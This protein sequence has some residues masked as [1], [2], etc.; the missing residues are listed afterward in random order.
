MV[1]Q[2]TSHVVFFFFLSFFPFL[3]FVYSYI[4][5]NRIISSLTK[6]CYIT[7]CRAAVLLPPQGRS[8][9][10]DQS[11]INNLLILCY[12]M[13]FFDMD[14]QSP[15]H[16][17][18]CKHVDDTLSQPF[19]AVQLTGSFPLRLC[20]FRRIDRRMIENGYPGDVRI[21]LQ[22]FLLPSLTR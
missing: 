9:S 20:Q 8:W 18:T 11:N 13:K 12:D 21:P 17:A 3:A 19:L 1:Y 7:S 4:A 16:A 2:G 22:G 6:P 15:K 14:F 10:P 5:A